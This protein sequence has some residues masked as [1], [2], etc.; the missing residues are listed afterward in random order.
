[1]EDLR[2]KR[3]VAVLDAFAAEAGAVWLL[4]PAQRYLAARVRTFVDLALERLGKTPPWVARD[5]V[6]RVRP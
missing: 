4:H 3:L 6:E 2:R 1:V 5:R